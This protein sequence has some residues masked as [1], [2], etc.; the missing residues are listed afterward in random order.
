MYIVV[1][2]CKRWANIQKIN[3]PE[4]DRMG[5]DIRVNPLCIFMLSSIF[6]L[7]VHAGFSPCRQRKSALIKRIIYIQPG[8]KRMPSSTLIASLQNGR[9]E[10]DKGPV[11]LVALA[12]ALLDVFV[13]V[14]DDTLVIPCTPPSACVFISP[15]QYWLAFVIS[16]QEVW[17]A[18]RRPSG[19]DQGAA[20]N[21]YRDS[22]QVISIRVDVIMFIYLRVKI[23]NKKPA[24]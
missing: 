23:I 4:M 12:N 9:H 20:G 11:A 22:Q 13:C 24:L 1:Y 5:K 21:L 10:E 6:I 16:D 19:S 7:L 15:L 3:R 8:T 14:K 17:A 18:E 2:S